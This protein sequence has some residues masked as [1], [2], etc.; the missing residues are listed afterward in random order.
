MSDTEEKEKKVYDHLFKVLLAGDARVGKSSLIKQYV[1][2]KFKPDYQ[3]TTTVDFAVK[4]LPLDRQRV[5][6]HIL[7]IPGDNT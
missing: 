5:K 4:N 6:L 2:F 7:D 3:K 1:D